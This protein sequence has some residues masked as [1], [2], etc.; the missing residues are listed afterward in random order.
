M[1]GTCLEQEDVGSNI[2]AGKVFYL[3]N[4][5]LLLPTQSKVHPNAS[6]V[7]EVYLHR[8]FCVTCKMFLDLHE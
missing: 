8:D 4:L 3:Q 6:F 7:F 1:K 2:G 5:H